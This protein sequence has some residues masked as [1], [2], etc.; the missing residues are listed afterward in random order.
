MCFHQV[1]VQQIGGTVGTIRTY[2]RETVRFLTTETL[3]TTL[4]ELLATMAKDAGT[5]TRP[6][7]QPPPIPKRIEEQDF[8]DGPLL[9]SDR[10]WPAALPQ[11]KRKGPPPPPAGRRARGTAPLG[12]PITSGLIDVRAMAEA[13]AAEREEAASPAVVAAPEEA[14]AEDE[15]AAE[16]AAPAP[17]LAKGTE[18]IDRVEPEEAPTERRRWVPSAAFA[19]RGA[20]VA[21]VAVALGGAFVF[22]GG[23]LER[24]DQDDTSAAA[25]LPRVENVA[26]ARP[27]PALVIAAA[28]EAAEPA[29]AV[30]PAAEPALADTTAAEPAV[31][32]TAAAETTAEPAVASDPVPEISA[33]QPP[34]VRVIP[35]PTEVT[36]V[37]RPAARPRVR[38]LA[39]RPV[40]VKASAVSGALPMRPSNSEI[41]SA[42]VAVQQ[43]L[44][45]CGALY[46]TTGAVP[47]Q[48]RVAPSGAI[49]SIAVKQGNTTFRSCVASALRGR[50]LPASQVGTTASFPV[51]IR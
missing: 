5:A 13:Y 43:R 23:L 20:V 4:E 6:A 2:Y 51:L 24:G 37:A 50:R 3:M 41:A 35:L 8:D 26:P 28:P 16:M 17:L 38:R 31:A 32:D 29:L 44:N 47:V 18:P 36:E 46:G 1:A 33:D 9:T 15:P 45:S 25:A 12:E 27:A 19:R 48:I 42:V 22:A 21:A 10:L 30:E 11:P 39:S 7:A 49:A 14:I 34:E 40:P